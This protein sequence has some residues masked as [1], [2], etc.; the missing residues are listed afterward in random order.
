MSLAMYAAPFDDD[1]SI[2]NKGHE[3]ED[4][5]NKKL[6]HNKT[7]KR[8]PKDEINHEKVNSVL[9][10][11][12]NNSSTDEEEQEH[13]G[14][15]NPPPKAHSAGVQKTIATEQM[16]NMTNNALTQSLGLQPLPNY[17]DGND[18]LDLNNFLSNYGDNKSVEEYYKKYIPNFRSNN[19]IR[20]INNSNNKRYYP[21]AN[22]NTYEQ[23]QSNP[24]N[25]LLLQKINYMINLLEEKQDEKTNNVT[26]EIILYSFLG[27]FIIF[28]VDSFTRVGKYVR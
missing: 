9:E 23:P 14:S 8:Y 19:S 28:I 2:N 4:L 7:Q 6:N 20:P 3:K 24:D 21:T 17:E 16:L 12:H 15:F 18:N 25:D 11:I 10:S 27:I 5:Y 22:S 26:E 13:L 1:V